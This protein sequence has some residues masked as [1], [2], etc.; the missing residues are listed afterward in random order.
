M[1]VE[2]SKLKKAYGSKV[3]LDGL[4]LAVPEGI[5]YGLVGKNGAGK[6]TLLNILSGI[7]EATSGEC[8]ICGEKI[9][10]GEYSSGLA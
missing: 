9:R 10:R 8:A 7:S 3:V 6:T 2:V 1:I 4:D 5:V